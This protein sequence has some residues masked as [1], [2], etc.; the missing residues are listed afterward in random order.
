[1][2]AHLNVIV[3]S[4]WLMAEVIPMLADNLASLEQR[5][6]DANEDD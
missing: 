3:L 2:L 1:M 6:T 5:R 4:L